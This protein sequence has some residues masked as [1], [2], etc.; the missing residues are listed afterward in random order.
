MS[1][2]QEDMF[3]RSQ[4]SASL[5]VDDEHLEPHAVI[6][7]GRRSHVQ[8]GDLIDELDNDIPMDM[9]EN[10]ER[11]RRMTKRE[12]AKSFIIYPENSSKASWDLFMAIVLVFTCVVTPLHICFGEGGNAWKVTNYTVDF[13]FLVDMVLIFLTAY[14]TEDF[15]LVDDHKT[16]ACEYLQG[17]FLIDALAIIPFDL[18]VPSEPSLI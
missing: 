2:E 15:V 16:I 11:F 9:D 18:L 6:S 10:D 13:L 4:T 5:K 8:Y 7:D 14:H 3:K 17:W 1:K 12:D